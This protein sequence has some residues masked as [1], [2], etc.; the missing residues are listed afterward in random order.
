MSF[1]ERF[2]TTSFPNSLPAWRFG[3]DWLRHGRPSALLRHWLL[4]PRS[5]T[6]RM[7]T[8][9]R[10]KFG[11][12]LVSQ[13]W[14]APRRDETRALALFGRERALVREVQLLCRGEPWVF[15]R[16]VIPVRTLSGSQRRLAHLG[17]KPLGAYLFADPTMQ[18]GAVEV[19][20]IHQGTALYR[21]AI[22]GLV[23]EPADL[24]ARRSMFWLAGKPLLVCEI[25][26]PAMAPCSNRTVNN[27]P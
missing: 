9:C 26:L 18:R 23:A 5:L 4:D 25:F 16:T 21:S 2:N 24:W 17:A 20:R 14:A 12:R 27:K 15:A 6:D 10:G 7:R 22:S 1:T 3:Q 19:A 8:C 11:V 13:G